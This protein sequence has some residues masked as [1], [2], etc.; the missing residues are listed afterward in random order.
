MEGGEDGTR[1]WSYALGFEVR[2]YECDIQGIVNN[3][4]YLHYFEH[5]RHGYLKDLGLDFAAMHAEGLDPVVYRLEIDYKSPLRP[6]DRFE[7]RLRVEREGRLKLV[8]F[9][10]AI[11]LPSGD[12]AGERLACAARVVVAM[13]RGGRPVPPTEELARLL[14]EGRA[15]GKAAPPCS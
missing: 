7:V 8:F 1:P 10:E 13:T 5:A 14:V 4:N 11:R 12:G 3:A 9:Q 6:G 2:D 15:D